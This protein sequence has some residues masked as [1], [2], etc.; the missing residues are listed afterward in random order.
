MF[1]QNTKKQKVNL[2]LSGPWRHYRGNRDIALLILNLSSKCM[3]S[4]TPRPLYSQKNPSVLI[5]LKGEL[6][7]APVWTV[8]EKSSKPCRY[9]NPGPSRSELLYRIRH[10]VYLPQRVCSRSMPYA[11]LL[12]FQK[13]FKSLGESCHPSLLVPL[14]WSI[15][16]LSA[17]RIFLWEIC[18]RDIW[19]IFQTVTTDAGSVIKRGGDSR[20]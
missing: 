4:I 7:T 6:A 14:F 10:P 17:A 5:Q 2:S 13:R 12:M 8:M 1:T 20:G 15:W 19:P 11:F 3:V 16:V 18:R 9:S